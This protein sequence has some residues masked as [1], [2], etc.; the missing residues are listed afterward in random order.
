MPAPTPE[1]LASLKVVSNA[2]EGGKP[3]LWQTIP[4]EDVYSRV[5]GGKGVDLKA[6][7]TAGFST[8]QADQQ[9]TQY[10][11]NTTPSPPTPGEIVVS[12][13]LLE[14][15]MSSHRRVWAALQS[16]EAGKGQRRSEGAAW[17]PVVPDA[18]RCSSVLFPTVVTDVGLRNYGRVAAKICG[19]GQPRRRERLLE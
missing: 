1:Q 11:P 4:I 2:A 5:T 19:P 18:A 7:Q 14:R 10:G 9:R 8:S 16:T 17:P 6:H 3:T 12:A 13:I 15:C